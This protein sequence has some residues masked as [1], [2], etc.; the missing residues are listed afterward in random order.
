MNISHIVVPQ[1]VPHFL[2]TLIP[3]PICG[4]LWNGSYAYCNKCML[5]SIADY[6]DYCYDP[7]DEF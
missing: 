2:S 6:P 7:T 4:A 5:E 3:C 1:A